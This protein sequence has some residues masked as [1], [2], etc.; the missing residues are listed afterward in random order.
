MIYRCW[1][2]GWRINERKK[3]EKNNTRIGSVH[4]MFKHHPFCSQMCVD[5]YKIGDA[6]EAPISDWNE[7]GWL[8]HDGD[9]TN[10]KAERK[11]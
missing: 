2:C 10:W 7:K 3:D 4:F 9:I 6:N 8:D 11:K 1:S 5:N